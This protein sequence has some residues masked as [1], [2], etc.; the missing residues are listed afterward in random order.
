MNTLHIE[1]LLAKKYKYKPL[2]SDL[3]FKYRQFF[4]E[5]IPD[6]LNINGGENILYTLNGSPICDGY[7]RIVIGDY[8]AFIE[9]SSSSYSNSYIVKPGQEFRISDKQ[10]NNRVKYV[11]MTIDDESDIKIYFQK[12]PVLYADYI[13]R[14]FYVSV[15]E[16]LLK[17][18]K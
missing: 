7:D 10:Y 6:F 2:T 16:V 15:H 12:K 17:E 9:F 11:W 8:G 13:P 5:N 18:S 1:S 3:S 14:K 4:K